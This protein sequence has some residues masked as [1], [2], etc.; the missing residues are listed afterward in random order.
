M[1]HVSILVKPASSACTMG[2]AYCFYRDLAEGRESG[3]CSV[4]GRDVMEAVVRRALEVGEDA[5]VAFDFQ[6][7]EPTVAG[8]DFFEAFVAEVDRGCG[9]QRVSYAIQTNGL[10]LD[11]EWCDFLVRHRF[12]VGVSVDG[13]RSLHDRLRPAADGS[14]T[15]GRV[16]ASVRRLRAHGLEPAIL[17]V[18]SSELSRHPQ[19]VYRGLCDLDARYVQFIPCLGPSGEEGA[20]LGPRAAEMARHALAP[21]RFAGFYRG[22]L[23]AWERGCEAGRSMSVGLFDDVM[24]LS[25]GRRPRTCGVLGACAP[26]FVVEADGSVYPCDFY[27][28]DRWL[29]GNVTT[30]SLEEMARG[31]VL[32]GFLARPRTAAAACEACRFRGMCHG[33]CPRLSG[34]FLAGDVCGYRDFLEYGYGRLASRAMAGRGRP[35][36]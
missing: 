29:M 17:C 31:A 30:D 36:A 10:A 32:R 13:T 12:L 28:E 2:C 26:Q 3:A 11:D 35:W 16:A 15:Y 9:G 6:G 22:F 4:M 18:L 7:G 23:G 1:R 24:A 5:R 8:L 14:G 21:E 19:Q 33:G 20:A 25:L 34:G 27:A